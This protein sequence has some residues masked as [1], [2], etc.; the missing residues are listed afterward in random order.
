LGAYK[1]HKLILSCVGCD[2]VIDKSNEDLWSSAEKFSRDGYHAIFDANG[3][4]TLN[5]SY[6]HLA[7][8]GK[9]IVYGWLFYLKRVFFL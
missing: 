9:L 2:H 6:T 3:V 8:M 7:P 5:D 4:A 1:Y